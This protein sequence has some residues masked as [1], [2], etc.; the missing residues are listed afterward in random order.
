MSICMSRVTCTII[1]SM[2]TSHIKVWTWSLFHVVLLIKLLVNKWTKFPLRWC[3]NGHDCVSNHQSH[4]CLLNR[5]FRRRSKKTSKLR[6]TGLCARNSPETGEFPAQK[7]S[8][9]HNVSIG[10]RHHEMA[11]V[12][13]YCL[14]CRYNLVW[15]R[16]E[17]ITFCWGHQIVIHS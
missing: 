16:H 10:W 8:N 9:T 6:V 2:S 5:L 11:T 1:S 15:R 12:L 4:N 17:D 7:A 13:R 14:V 3:H